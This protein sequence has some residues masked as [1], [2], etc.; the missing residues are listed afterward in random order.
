MNLNNET[1][2]IAPGNSCLFFFVCFIILLRIY[3]LAQCTF[4]NKNS[5]GPEHVETHESTVHFF[6]LKISVPLDRT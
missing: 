6:P 2:K 1:M 3:N 4:F 5:S